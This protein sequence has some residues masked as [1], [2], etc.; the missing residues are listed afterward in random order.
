MATIFFRLIVGFILGCGY[1]HASIGNEGYG[2]V[3][4]GIYSYFEGIPEEAQHAVK[5]YLLP[6]NSPL[7]EPLDKIFGGA[8]VTANKGAMREAGFEM[9]EDQG[10]HVV[11]ASHKKL[12][13][14]LVKVIL[15]KFDPNTKDKGRDWEHW[16]RRIEGEKV[17]R[18]AVAELGYKK[19]F[20]VPRQWIYPLP[21]GPKCPEKE[22]YEPKY[23]I[24]IVEDMRLDSRKA[25]SSFYRS[26]GKK[27]LD[28][29]YT[30]TTKYGLS[31]CC[32]KHNLPLCRDGK[33]AFVDTET[34]HNWPINYHRM[35]EFLSESGRAYW[36]TLRQ[37]NGP[38]H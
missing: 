9:T 34:Y 6:D 18:Q 16:I 10:L 4:K 5:P 23:F 25:N 30:I 36:K 22:G 1:V 19:Y 28:A 38:R 12:K 17:I 27:W 29:I 8:R 33:L 21:P 2:F 11:V 13:G 37:Q 7:W 15:D 24:L 26:I 20:K 3:A 14:Y 35:V 31:D 32:N